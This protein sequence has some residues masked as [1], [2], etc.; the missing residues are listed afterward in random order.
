MRIYSTLTT[1]LEQGF[2]LFEIIFTFLDTHDDE[3][4]CFRQE[5]GTQVFVVQT[6]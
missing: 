3:E 2:V 6:P 1:M 4:S 5:R